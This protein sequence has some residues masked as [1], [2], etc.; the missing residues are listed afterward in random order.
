MHCEHIPQAC[1]VYLL[2]IA[3]RNRRTEISRVFVRLDDLEQAELAQQEMSSGSIIDP[4]R[5]FDNEYRS[6]RF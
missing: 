3:A 6:R 4:L 5:R 2:S 1:S